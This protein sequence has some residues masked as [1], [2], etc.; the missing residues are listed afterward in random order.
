MDAQVLFG[1]VGVVTASGVVRPEESDF[2]MPARETEQAW[3][4][5]G[6]RT[7][8]VMKTQHEATQTDVPCCRPYSAAHAS[9]TGSLI[10]VEVPGG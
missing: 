5:L 3:R 10:I 9:S 1:S 8:S 4:L 2:A 6:I 7:R